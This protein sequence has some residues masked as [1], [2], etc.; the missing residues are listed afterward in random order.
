MKLPPTLLL[1][2]LQ[3]VKQFGLVVLGWKMARM[4]GVGQMDQLGDI[5]IGN[6][7]NQMMAREMRIMP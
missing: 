2:R 1:N 3:M 6:L 4:S 5:L 7:E